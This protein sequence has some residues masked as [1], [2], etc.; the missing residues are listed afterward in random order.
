[1]NTAIRAKGSAITATA[2]WLANFMIGQVSSIAFANIG[3]RYYLVFKV[4]GATNALVF[5]AFFPETGGRTLEEMDDFFNR[6]RLFIA[7][8]KEATS[9]RSSKQVTEV[10]TGK[11]PRFS[12]EAALTCST[13]LMA[14]HDFTRCHRTCQREWFLQRGRKDYAQWRTPRVGLRA[15]C[16]TR[17]R[18]RG[19]V[20]QKVWRIT[21]R[22]VSRSL[23]PNYWQASHAMGF[24]EGLPCR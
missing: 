16:V 7:F 21:E 15:G 19:V 13:L 8:D 23:V 20:A 12:P 2:S 11:S 1:M 18:S 10:V 17:R 4:C 22:E 3:W 14:V 24:T 6:G 5:W 9:G